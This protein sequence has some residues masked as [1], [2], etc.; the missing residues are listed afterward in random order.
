MANKVTH[1]VNCAGN[2]VRN[3]WESI[4]IAYLTF[5]WVDQE[6]QILFD[7]QNKVT[8]QI[9]EF[10]NSA[11]ERSQSLLVHSVRGQSRS[12]CVLATYMMRKYNWSMIKTLEF[13]NSRRPDLEIRV[14]FIRQLGEYEQ[15][16]A[17][18][19]LGPMTVTWNDISQKNAFLESEELLLRN[20]FLN[21]KPKQRV[22]LNAPP[23]QVRTLVQWV[24]FASRGSRNLAVEDADEKDLINIVNPPPVMRHHQIKSL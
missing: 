13:L 1:I 17:S 20:T 4:G 11:A 5:N 18:R 12:S 10:I 15:R 22:D 6:N 8:D 3:M 7:S 2:S 14:T 16:L 19:N 9:F 24:D 23:S 21:A